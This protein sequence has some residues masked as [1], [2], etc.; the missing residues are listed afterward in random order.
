MR[1]F[2][3]ERLYLRI[4]PNV[5]CTQ[6]TQLLES[7]NLHIDGAKHLY[8]YIHNVY[9]TSTDDKNWSHCASFNG[10]SVIIIR[11][12][13]LKIC[14]CGNNFNNFVVVMMTFI[15]VYGRARRFQNGTTNGWRRAKKIIIIRTVVC[16]RY[17]IAKLLFYAQIHWIK[18]PFP[19][20]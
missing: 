2:S 17:M 10:L 18:M 5:K 11:S 12:K 9:Y 4:P 14:M 19:L 6:T 15:C 7:H 20:R 1:N 8:I 13:A 3:F 16:A